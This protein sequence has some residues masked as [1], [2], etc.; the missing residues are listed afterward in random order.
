MLDGVSRSL[1]VA[2]GQTVRHLRGGRTQDEVASAMRALGFT[3]TQ[4]TVT[5]LENGRRRLV[6]EESLGLLAA[7]HAVTGEDLRLADLL[8]VDGHDLR[9]ID[10]L[11][12]GVEI[13]DFMRLDP[14]AVRKLLAGE[15]W[16]SSVSEDDIAVRVIGPDSDTSEWLA[17]EIDRRSAKILDVLLSTMTASEQEAVRV[18]AGGEAER[19]AARR[20]GLP[21]ELVAAAARALWGRSLSA[22]RDERAGAGA[23]PQRRGRMTRDLL[24]ELTHQVVDAID[25]QINTEGEDA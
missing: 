14:G 12:G 16:P 21:P 3:W 23:T 9:P 7:L 6:L 19:K 17:A 18:E 22:E 10:G 25:D 5:E 13:N 11:T 4:A 1:Q 24:A 15:S 8:D 20:L 2:V